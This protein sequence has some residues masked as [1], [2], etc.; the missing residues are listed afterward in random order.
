MTN[1]F[2][3]FHML[4]CNPLST[5]MQSKIHLNQ[6]DNTIFLED[7]YPYLQVVGTL[8]H[9]IVNNQSDCA[10]AVNTLA[11]YLSH[12]NMCTSIKENFAIY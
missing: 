4:N 5:P 10:Y 6:G 9:A 1:K 2:A 11:Q 12:P 8:M 3:K 7:P